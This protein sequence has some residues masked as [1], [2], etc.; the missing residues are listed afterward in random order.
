MSL[1]PRFAQEISPLFRV[2]DD[3][4]R[5]SRHWSNSLT[6]E[7]R[8]FQPKF[9][10]K[11]LKD[12][13]ELHGELP[14]IDQKDISIEW[15]DGNTLTISGKTEKNVERGTRPTAAEAIEDVPE[16]SGAIQPA[17]E[18]ESSASS[19]HYQ[20]PSVADEGADEASTVAGD[21]NALTPATTNAG[22]TAKDAQPQQP[23]GK[24][25]ISERSVGQFHRSFSFPS[26]VDHEAVKANL[27]NGILSIVVPKSQAPKTR[28]I[29]VQ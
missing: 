3:Y 15:T 7:L 29:E 26:R 8:S 4:E 28:R 27:K 9:D 10:V 1:F 20:P 12:A 18:A 14:G 17:P 25:W 24:Y 21:H 22:E 2:L 13:Y 23:E 19:E 5:A 16:A 6:S 11:E